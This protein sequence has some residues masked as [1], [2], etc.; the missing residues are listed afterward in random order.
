MGRGEAPGEAPAGHARAGLWRA[1]DLLAAGRAKEAQAL[2][3]PLTEKGDPL[4]LSLMGQAL[5]AQGEHARAVGF[6][7]EARDFNSLRAEAEMLA[8]GGQTAEAEL[9][10]QAAYEIRPETIANPYAD[11]LDKARGLEAA[12][13]FLK[14]VMNSFPGSYL[15][16]QWQYRMGSNLRRQGR[17]VEAE[18]VFRE[19]LEERPGTFYLMTGLG[20]VYY[21]Q[22]ER[23]RAIEQFEQ[24]IQLYPQ[25]GDGYLAMGMALAQEGRYPEADDWL[26]EANR[27]APENLTWCLV[28]GNSAQEAENWPLAMEAFLDCAGR[29]PEDGRAYTALAWA[30]YQIQDVGAAATAM[31]RAIELSPSLDFNSWMQAG[32]IFE[33]NGDIEEAREAYEKALFIQPD[34]E[35]AKKG[36][37]RMK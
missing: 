35:T 19:A 34:N 17:L 27:L 28:R 22:G 26:K 23:E 9:A 30:Y 14:K 5:A 37:E 18:G 33:R 21:E 32:E 3:Q 4:A 36:M 16:P 15:R 7:E 8:A 11:F 1:Q 12:E 25:K 6:W 10:F 2:L 13:V 31:Q 29:F 20:W 24:V